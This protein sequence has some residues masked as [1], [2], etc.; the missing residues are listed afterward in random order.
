MSVESL[1]ISRSNY[2][3]KFTEFTRLYKEYELALYCFFEGEDSKYF[4]IRI[5]NI[6][7]PKKDILLSCGGKKGV[8]G[9]HR[10][11]LARKEYENIKATYFIDKD[12]DASIRERGLS[13]IYETPCYSI[14]NFYTSSECFSNILKS[15][16]K[17]T[18]IDEDFGRCISLYTRLQEEFHD[19]VELLNAWIACQRQNSSESR[20]QEEFRDAIEFLDAWIDCQKKNSSE[21]KISN[22]SIS[23]FVNIGL[24]K[25]TVG[26]ATAHVS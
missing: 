23:K 3:T 26:R 18:E 17:L 6:A 5:K 2:A 8:L 13:Q 4:G 16:F 19:A 12:F 10:M 11:I 21:L 14:E 15:E 1:R 7:R 25:I 9:I 22:L 20:L 24:D